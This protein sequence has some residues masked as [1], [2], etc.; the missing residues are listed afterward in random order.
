MHLTHTHHVSAVHLGQ[1]LP[2]AMHRP[3]H[4]LMSPK[5]VASV[6]ISSCHECVEEMH[7]E[8]SGKLSPCVLPA[9]TRIS[10]T[11]AFQKRTH[12]GQRR[13]FLLAC[14]RCIRRC[15]AVISL[16]KASCSA[17]SSIKRCETDSLSSIFE[18][19]TFD[20]RGQGRMKA[21]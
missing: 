18:L 3:R 10:S 5:C 7:V 11:H 12:H 19:A 15:S 4:R 17:L 14:S 21:Y 9:Q 6:M 13:T 1:F 8:G 16:S 20:S 2:A